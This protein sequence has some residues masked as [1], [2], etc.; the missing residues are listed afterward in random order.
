MRPILVIDTET[1][2]LDPEVNDIWQIAAYYRDANERVFTID[3][4][5]RPDD[6]NSVHPQMLEVCHV[7]KEQ[8]ESFPPSQQVYQQFRNFLLGIQPFG[9]KLIWVGYNT[10]FDMTFMQ[11]FFKVHDQ[12][13]SIYNFFDKRA[14][15]LLPFL[16][17]L[18]SIDIIN[19]T[20]LKLETVYWMFGQ[21][22]ETA[23]NALEDAR[24]T[25]M[26]YL[27]IEDLLK[28]GLRHEQV[29]YTDEY[30][31]SG[32]KRTSKVLKS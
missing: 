3:L 19:P 21:G 31:H 23:H 17:M 13:D 22:T 25:Y 20:N 16:Q 7:T 28:K 8:L 29:T 10:Q 14:I 5:C 6:M 24:V 11:K 9:S 30:T 12:G 18:R 4:K 32:Q 2:G 26:F 15:D 1:T 27:W